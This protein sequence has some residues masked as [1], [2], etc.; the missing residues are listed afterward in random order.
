MV[1]NRSKTNYTPKIGVVV[2]AFN[3]RQN[4][5]E[6]LSSLKKVNYKNSIVILVDDGSSDGTAEIVESKFPEVK[7]IKGSGNLWWS[8][9]TNLG[10]EH[11]LNEGCDY[12]YTINNDVLLDANIF[13]VLSN[14]AKDHKNAIIGSKIYDNKNRDKVW[15]FGAKFDRSSKDIILI[16]GFDKDFTKLSTVD[17]LTGMGMLIPRGVFEDV[18]YFD[19]KKM[20]QYLAD[21]DLG[22]RAKKHGFE[23][24]VEPEAKVYSKIDSSWLNK[25]LAQP[26]L[27][28]VYDCYFAKR[29]PYSLTVRYEFYK[30]HWADNYIAALAEFYARF[31]Y[32]FM[33]RTFLPSY[34]KSKFTKKKKV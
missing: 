13:K 9:A 24:L 20:P 5:L 2:P 34:L 18:G 8:A 4:V 17:I 31:T 10:I 12:I 3:D 25:Q 16:A 1:V 23:L 14:T 28:F 27:R 29:S 7:V 33:I 26:K 32:H 19:A 21:S 11:A 6:F 30:R 15:F 22:L